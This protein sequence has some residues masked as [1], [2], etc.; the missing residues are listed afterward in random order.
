MQVRGNSAVQ[1][2]FVYTDRPE[3][4]IREISAKWQER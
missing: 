3:D 4:V 1:I 2:F